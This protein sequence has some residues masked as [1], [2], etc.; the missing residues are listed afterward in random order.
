MSKNW[1]KER[2]RFL[3]LHYFKRKFSTLETSKILNETE[4]DPPSYSMIKKWFRLFKNNKFDIKLKKQTGRKINV[5][6]NDIVKNCIEKDKTLSINSISK[7]TKISRR[8]VTTILKKRLHLRWKRSRIIPHILKP[9][10][11]NKRIKYSAENLPILNDKENIVITGDETILRWNNSSLYKWYKKNER[12]EITEKHSISSKKSMVTIFLSKNGIEFIDI[13][14]QK[15][16]MNAHYFLEKIIKPLIRKIKKKYKNKRLFLHYDNAPPHRPNKVTN[17]I[18]S[19]NISLMHHPPY[20]PD[21]A[22]L[23]FF[24]FSHF[25]NVLL[26]DFKANSEKELKTFILNKVKETKVKTFGAAF[27]RWIKKLKRVIVELGE[28]QFTKESK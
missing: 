24:Y 25:K 20:S 2:D 23:D 8:T 5:K 14:P 11:L 10:H 21:L 19:N 7:K 28:F 26:K 22:P 15:E 27:E 9:V 16:K 13:M 17:Y 3:I 6:Y 4:I 1:V 18:S 12:P